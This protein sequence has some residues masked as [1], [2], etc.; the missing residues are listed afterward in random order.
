MYKKPGWLRLVAVSFL[1]KPGNPTV[2]Y[3]TLDIEGAELKVLKTIPFDKVDIRLLDIEMNHAGEV[4]EGTRSDIRSFLFKNGYRFYRKVSI[5]EMF[6]KR[7][8]FPG[9]LSV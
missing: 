9:L 4:F 7:D 6:V 1:L 3:M 2:D 8:V 5:D